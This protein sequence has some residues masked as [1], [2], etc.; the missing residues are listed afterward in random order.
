M[1]ITFANYSQ[2]E[3]FHL[4]PEIFKIGNEPCHHRQS[5]LNP[6]EHKLLTLRLL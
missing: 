3:G 1:W 5:A 2:H 6:P 4:L